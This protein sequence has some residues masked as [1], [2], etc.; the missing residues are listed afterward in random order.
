MGTKSRHKANANCKY[1][2]TQEVS[3]K[4]FE[5][6]DTWRSQISQNRNLTIT[7]NPKRMTEMIVQDCEKTRS[8]EMKLLRKYLGKFS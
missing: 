6:V 8:F 4:M 2:S 7:R 5:K 1:T 3:T